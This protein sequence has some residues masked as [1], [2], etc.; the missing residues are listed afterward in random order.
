MMK[1]LMLRHSILSSMTCSLVARDVP[2]GDGDGLVRILRCAPCSRRA[3]LARCGR[4]DATHQMLIEHTCTLAAC[5]APTAGSLTQQENSE[6]PCMLSLQRQ[7]GKGVMRY[8]PATGKSRHVSF[9]EW[10]TKRAPAFFCRKKKDWNVSEMNTLYCANLFMCR[11][12]KLVSFKCIERQIN[13]WY[14]SV[15]Y[16]LMSSNVIFGLIS[17]FKK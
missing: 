10:L 5:M 12:G 3:Y 11:E 8:V 16:D 13:K 4:S 6:T 14:M 2:F 7:G 1:C 9:E 17:I 15:N